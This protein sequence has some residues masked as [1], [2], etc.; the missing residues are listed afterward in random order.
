MIMLTR[1]RI[2]RTMT[3]TRTRYERVSILNSQVE[4]RWFLCQFKPFIYMKRKSPMQDHKDY[5]GDKFRLIERAQEDIYFCKLDEELLEKM[6]I[7]SKSP[8]ERADKFTHF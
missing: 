5:L 4:D 3:T 1:I 7:V 8:F 6:G 2:P